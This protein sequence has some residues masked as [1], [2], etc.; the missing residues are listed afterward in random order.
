MNENYHETTKLCERH[1]A[2]EILDGDGEGW[3]GDE[4]GG[5]AVGTRKTGGNGVRMMTT[6]PCMWLSSFQRTR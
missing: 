2:G 1:K 5:D 4:G 3:D 6:C